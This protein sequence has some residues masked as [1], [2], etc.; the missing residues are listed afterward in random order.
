MVRDNRFISAPRLCVEMIRRFR[1]RLSVRGIIN[2]I[3]AAGYW[4]SRPARCPRLTWDHRR[5]RRVC[6]R[7]HR[8]SELRH[9]RHCVFSDES[10][11]TLF[12]SDGR[13]RVRCR[14]GKRLIDAC[15]Q[16]KDGNHGPSLRVWGAIHHGARSELV[17]LNGTLNCERYVRLFRDS[18]L[19]WMMDVLDETLFM[20]RTMPL[21]TQHVT[22]QL[23]WQKM[24]WRSWTGQLGVQ[25]S[26]PLSM[27]RTK[28]GSRSETWMAPLPLCQKCGV[29]S[30]RRVLQFAQE[31]WGPWWTACHV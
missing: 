8:I 7:M 15:I 4:S 10:H 29:L 9:W 12:H 14:K 13:I 19:S 22:R 16:P 26:I 11:F 28:W 21:T 30:S 23:F 27:F 1:R 31:G 20:S 17:V 18:M 25:T 6:G 24:M 2:R 5:H 3:L